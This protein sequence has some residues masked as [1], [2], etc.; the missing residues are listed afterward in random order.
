MAL[1]YTY[2]DIRAMAEALLKSYGLEFDRFIDLGK[3][4]QLDEPEL[5]DFWLIWGQSLVT[6]D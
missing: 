5:R 4:D 3:N 6:K 1:I 2:D